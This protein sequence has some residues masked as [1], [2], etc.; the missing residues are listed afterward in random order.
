MQILI[1]ILLVFFGIIAGWFLASS[2]HKKDETLLNELKS[3]IA[4]FENSANEL[5]K[6][7][8]QKENLIGDLR[9]SLESSQKAKT[10]AETRLEEANKNIEEQKK[11][12][13]QAQ[14]KLTTA[15]Q[16]LSGEALKSNNKAFLELARENLTVILSKAKGDFDT[17]ET[18]IKNLVQPL[19]DS[20][21]KY[22]KQINELEKNRASDYANLDSQIKSLI[23]SEQQ[24]QKETGNL[25]SALRRPEVRGRWGEITLKRVV[26]LAGMSEHCDYSEQVSVNTE[27]GRSR[28]DMIIHLP[29]DRE[30]V[31]DSKVPLDSYLDAIA[32]DTEE[33][34]KLFL[35][36]HT[37]QVRKHIKSLSEKNYWN[38]FPKAP[39]FVVMFMPAESFLSAALENDPAIIEDG[40]ASK[41]IIATPTTL[42]A[43]LRAVAYG[44]RQEQIT[45]NA[46][47][48]ADLGKEL[49]KRFEPFI[50]HINKTGTNL[51]QAVTSFNNMV[52]SLETRVLVSV[53]KF[54]ELGACENKDLPE[55]TSIEQIPVRSQEENN[56]SKDQ[57]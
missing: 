56:K 4:V 30:I 49:Y 54:K 42:V 7:I 50:E 10:T 39:E 52:N 24:L 48:I 55:I 17:K 46:Q 31:V 44:W 18:A 19:A 1:Y 5:Q 12:L 21:Q 37:Q 36:K 6:Q 9:S 40:I 23:S 45:E 20:L 51:K 25:V 2:K 15:F 43:L 29:N 53:R 35:L 41:V 3:Q 16:A 13:E 27:E 33:K 38:Q 47:K 14:E 32:Q 26:E 28:P 22:E 11:L 8:G 34:K 57:K